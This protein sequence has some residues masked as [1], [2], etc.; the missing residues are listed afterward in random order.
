MTDLSHLSQISAPLPWHLKEWAHLQE[1]LAGGQLPHALLLVGGQ[2]TGKSQ[3][4]LA[5]SR[6]LLC[7]QT[8][9]LLNCGRC[10]ACELSGSGNH[11][12][13]RWVE[14]LEKSRVIKIEQ[15]RGVMRFTNK[16]A[17][18]GLRKVIVLAP[19][20]S[21]NANAF[22]AL[23]K[24]LEEPPK[25]SYLILVCHR[26][27][28]I[29]ATIRSRCQI[30]RLA[31]PHTE[32]CL[33][34]LDRT[35]GLREQSEQLLSLADGMPLLAQQL[36]SSGRAEDFSEKRLGLRALLGG[37]ISV[38]QAGALWSEEHVSAFLDQI[39]T[40]L[41]RLLNSLSL[42]W[43]RSREGRAVFHL[44]DEVVRLQRAVSAGANPSKQLLID[45]LLSKCR[46]ELGNGHL[47][48]NIQPQIGAARV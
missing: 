29:P 16:T 3:L 28:R 11:G 25:D 35:T 33:E 46:R 22:N 23:L 6:L 42:E 10:H 41:Q 15:I 12:D 27:Y 13:F 44:L 40:E 21:M 18:F 2:C 30:L 20:D 36:Y 45:A 38:F 37:D 7:V 48:D 5:L 39:A 43:L 32:S 8:E 24:L 31:T 34:W 47:G 26:M 17:S 9:G 19:A 1:Q 4:A 14:P